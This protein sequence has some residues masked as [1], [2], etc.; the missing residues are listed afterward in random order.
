MTRSVLLDVSSFFTFKIS[1]F[2]ILGVLSVLASPEPVKVATNVS[3]PAPP[4]TLSVLASES[5]T[6]NVNVSLPV[7]PANES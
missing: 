5:F 6:V 2:S 7:P 1:I 4:S 3:V